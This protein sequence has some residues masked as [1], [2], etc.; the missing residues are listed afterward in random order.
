MK[1]VLVYFGMFAVFALFFAS[2][3]RETFD[4]SL[5]IGK[6]ENNNT[7]GEFYR[8]LPDGTGRMWNESVDWFEDEARQTTWTLNDSELEVEYLPFMPGDWSVTR[9]FTI[10]VLNSTTL[11]YRDNF[12]GR[13]HSFTRVRE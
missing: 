6:W 7:P 10:T 2:C 11:R 5:L 1:K 8:Y 4:E 12:D 13:V 9:V 3:G